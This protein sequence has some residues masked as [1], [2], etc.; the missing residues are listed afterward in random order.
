MHPRLRQQVER[1]PQDSI[2]QRLQRPMSGSSCASF[3]VLFLDQAL[4]EALLS[5]RQLYVTVMLR[6]P[7][8]SGM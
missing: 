5:L 2:E 4:T 6:I 7:V 1:Q 8:S 3:L